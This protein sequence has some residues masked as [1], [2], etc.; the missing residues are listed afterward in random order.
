M[1]D[2]AP[3]P[4]LASPT[5]TPDDLLK[6]LDLIEG[7]LLGFR[8]K[9]VG[10]PSQVHFAYAACEW[11]AREARQLV[12]TDH[13]A[14]A[15]T[16]IGR[17][18]GWLGRLNRCAEDAEYNR[19][20]L[21][22]RPILARH[23]GIHTGGSDQDGNPWSSFRMIVPKCAR[24]DEETIRGYQIGKIGEEKYFCGDCVIRAEDLPAA[25]G[26]SPEAS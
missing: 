23:E 24:C 6:G 16:R 11:E 18:L 4:S 21:V 25:A 12:T 9:N 8:R 7:A 14:L 15:R 22:E 19:S 1:I 26:T 5:L 2:A 3:V 10:V 13:P 17:S 20:G